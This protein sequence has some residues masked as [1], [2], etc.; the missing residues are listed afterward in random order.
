LV[1]SLTDSYATSA[2]FQGTTVAC[3]AYAG[4]EL[5]FVDTPGILVRV[6]TA[7]VG[8]ALAMLRTS[9]HVLLVVSAAHLDEDLADLLPF[10]NGKLGIPNP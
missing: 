7:A 1:S 5:S 3:E 6:D 4:K 10:V 8:L 2:H 9:A